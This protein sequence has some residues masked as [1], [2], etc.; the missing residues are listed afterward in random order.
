LRGN[1]VAVTTEGT[2]T[3]LVVDVEAGKVTVAIETDQDG[4]HM[5]ALAPAHNRAF[6][7]NIGS[8]SVSVVD[9]KEK[10]R[11][12]NIPTGAGTEGIA[13]GRQPQRQLDL[14]YRRRYAQGRRDSPVEIL[15]DSRQVHRRRQARTRLE[16]AVR[17]SGRVGR[18]GAAR[19]SAHQH[20]GAQGVAMGCTDR[21]PGRAVT[22]VRRNAEPRSG[23]RDRSRDV[24]SR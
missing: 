23:R 8:G 12:A 9:L 6:V 20:A 17:R 3:L 21:H 18:C 14:D 24:A 2:K 15:P 13:M 1:E 16:R 11:I 4:S 22:S 5:V 10:R 19:T 7:A